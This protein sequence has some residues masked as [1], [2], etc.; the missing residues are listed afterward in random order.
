[1]VAGG[2]V[3]YSGASDALRAFAD[4]HGVPVTETQA[5]KSALAWDHPLQ[6]GAVGVTGSTAASALAA[7]A[8]LVLAVGT[9]LQDFTTGSHALFTKAKRIGLN[10][11]PVDAAKW[12]SI[13]LVADARVGLAALS[14]AVKGWKAA[15]EWTERAREDAEQWRV[16]VGKLTGVREVALPYEGDVIGA[17]QRSTFDSEGRDIVVCA[18]GT[19][20]AELH[21][22][23]RA[24]VPG[25]YHVEYG[26]SCMGYEIAGGVGVKMARPEREVVVILGDGSYL[27]LNS[28][29]AT[30]VMLGQ[31]L[32]VVV[33]DNR[34]FGCINRLQQACGGAPFNN[35]LADCLHGPQGAPA[36]DFAAHASALGARAENVRTV[37]ELEAALARARA[38]DRTYVICI[39]TD[40]DR[41][42]EAG[43]AWW[44]VA[45]PEVSDRAGVRKARAGY[46]TEKKR[47]QP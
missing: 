19:L 5:G 26:Y 1:M 9:R 13:P 3:L 11:N 2:G 23:W 36:V 30:S 7:D 37:H 43:G 41:T 42:T 34:G 24:A 15:G 8:D 39:E 44:E 32:V 31:K 17:V 22:L 4:A 6:I 29:L 12:H 20:P 21:K 28:E 33:L 27:M 46:E 10:V 35:L 14:A 38:S 16:T 25:A 45:V 40:P 18:A 47:Q